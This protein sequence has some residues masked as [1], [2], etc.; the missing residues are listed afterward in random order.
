MEKMLNDIVGGSHEKDIVG[1]RRRVFNG[2]AL[3]TTG[4]LTKKD[5]MKNKHGEIVSI[6]ASKAAKKTKNLRKFLQPKGS[7]AFGP[8]KTKKNK[9]NKTSNRK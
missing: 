1:S 5:L 6:K 8:K 2:N 7:G 3:R 9:R 4:G